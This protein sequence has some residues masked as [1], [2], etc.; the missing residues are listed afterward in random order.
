MNKNSEW[1]GL[2]G[3]AVLAGNLIWY[4][5]S[6]VWNFV[7]WILL[8]AALA[9]LGF[10]IFDFYKKKHVTKRYFKQGSNLVVQV[11]VVLAIVSML[12]FITTRRHWRAD[13]T[14]NQRFSR[15]S[16]TVNLVKGLDKE[17]ELKAFVRPENQQGFQDLLDEYSY[18][19]SKLTYEIIDPDE[20]VDVTKQYNVTAYNTIVVECGLKREAVTQVSEENLTNAI[21]KVTRE[22]DKVIYFITGHGERDITDD[23]PEGLKKA[24]EAIKKENHIVRKLNLVRRRNVPDSA[25][26]VV[27]AS[28]KVSF[29][30]GELDSLAAF[31]DNGGKAL[32]MLDPDGP[33]DLR[34]FARRYKVEAADNL[35]FDFS[36]FGRLFGAGPSVPMVQSYAEHAITKGFNVMTFYPQA[37]SVTPMS[38]KDGWNIVELLK[39]SKQSW[40]VF[41]YK[42]KK[43]VDQ[44]TDKPGPI[45]LAAISEKS[46]NGGKSI[47]AIFGDSDFAKN[48]YFGQQGNADLFLNTVNFL[49]E[50]EDLISVRPKQAK[51]SRLNLTAAEVTTVFWLVVVVMPVLLVI[52]GVVVFLRRSKA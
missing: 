20:E 35:V 32:L 40:A 36:G 43:E 19:S 6:N 50:E 52:L 4:S 7:N 30:P 31:I 51:D 13:L 15:A 2:A 9:G 10:Y 33:A 1:I 46:Q 47:A 37:S 29:F 22:Q 34:E 16:Q 17:V 49:A 27:T 21:I 18:L 11:I 39:T 48:G 28:P 24:V 26:V 45:T 41:D 38:E 44:S 42:N 8:I 12:A 14:E 25:S 23:S 3:L 5:I